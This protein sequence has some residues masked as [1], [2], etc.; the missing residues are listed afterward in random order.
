MWQRETVIFNNRFIVYKHIQKILNFLRFENNIFNLL[1]SV[2][3]ICSVLSGPTVPKVWSISPWGSIRPFPGERRGE[4]G[5][6]SYFQ[7]VVRYLSFS[8][9]W[10]LCSWCKNNGG[11]NCWYLNINQGSGANSTHC[12]SHCQALVWWTVIKSLVVVVNI[13]LVQK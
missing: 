3:F 5:P 13:R 6:I 7:I 8:L 4:E 2:F 9:C 10:H 11:Y 12:V 1:P